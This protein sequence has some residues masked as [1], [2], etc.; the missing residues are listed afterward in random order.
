MN[1]ERSTVKNLQSE[2]R[3]PNS[4]IKIMIVEDEVISARALERNLKNLG[5]SVSGRVVSGEEA[6]KKAEQDKPDLVLM[7]IEL[8]GEMDGIEAAKIIRSHFDICSIYIT[9]YSGEETLERAKI[10][11]PY[12]YIIK[13]CETRELHANIEIALYKNK[14][15]KER[16]REEEE[17]K[18]LMQELQDSLVKVRL[19]SGLIPVCSN[20][21]DIRNDE[22]YWEQI[23]SYIQHHSEA[24]FSHGICPKCTKKLYLEYCEEEKE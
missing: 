15:E 21:K 4:E 7:D 9:A 3:N 17:R 18:K 6:I 11:E 1:N 5:Y 8:K 22:G 23:E 12:G 13:S 10:A 14:V 2:F 24:L 16:K 20:C 19:L